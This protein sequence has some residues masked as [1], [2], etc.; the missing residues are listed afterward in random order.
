MEKRFVRTSTLATLEL[1]STFPHSVPPELID[2]EL[3]SIATISG[4]ASDARRGMAM[5][6]AG[7]GRFDGVGR[8]AGVAL[9]T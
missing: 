3:T 4:G 7:F 6:G 8:A 2:V 9:S 5:V 1:V